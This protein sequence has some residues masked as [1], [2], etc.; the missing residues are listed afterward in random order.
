MVT[1]IFVHVGEAG[2]DSEELA[3]D[4]LG[5]GRFV[6]TSAPFVDKTLARGDIVDAVSMD[7]RWHVVD[8]AVR[9]GNSTLRI[10]PGNVDVITPLLRLGLHVEQGPAGLVAVS[11]G[12]TDPINGLMNWLAEA[13]VDVSPGYLSEKHYTD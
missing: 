2:V 12:P 11:L 4:E 5:Q 8:V 10:L 9:G 7:G 3:A 13:G 6:V 1:S